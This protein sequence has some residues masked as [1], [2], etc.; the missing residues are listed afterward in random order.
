MLTFFDND[1]VG[2]CECIDNIMY[3][4]MHSTILQDY[5]HST[6]SLTPTEAAPSAATTMRRG[7]MK[8][9]DMPMT[10]PVISMMATVASLTMEAREALKR[11]RKQWRAIIQA[12]RTWRG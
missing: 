3:I 10:P 7:T 5:L 6:I 1:G 4:N 2:V 9:T 8:R 12:T 11:Q